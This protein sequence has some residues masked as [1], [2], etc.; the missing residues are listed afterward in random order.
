MWMYVCNWN[1]KS[2]LILIETDWN[3]KDDDNEKEENVLHSLCQVCNCLISVFIC[4]KD[5]WI[6]V[7][8]AEDNEISAKDK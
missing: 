8:T 2:L 1:Q 6:K 5:C 3:G 4:V 7:N